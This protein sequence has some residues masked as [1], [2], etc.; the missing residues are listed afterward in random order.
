MNSKAIFSATLVSLLAASHAYAVPPEGQP[1][2]ER[3]KATESK[4]HRERIRILEEAERCIQS[5]QDRR[6]YRECERRENAARQ[7]LRDEIRSERQAL[8]AEIEAR[9]AA[10]GGPEA[11]L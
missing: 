10:R 6:A 4:S 5:A 8:R 11:R 7:A 1:L 3:F 9:R 2:F